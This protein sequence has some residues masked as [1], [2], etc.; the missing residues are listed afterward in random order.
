MCLS[1]CGTYTYSI[2]YTQLYILYV[3][4]FSTLY[5]LYTYYSTYVLSLHHYTHNTLYT[6]QYTL[7]SARSGYS[8][9]R[10]C[11]GLWRPGRHC[12]TRPGPAVSVRLSLCTLCCIDYV[13]NYVT[14]CICKTVAMYTLL[15]RLCA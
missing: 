6:I 7:R 9:L 3:Y 13:H 11:C 5:I 10:A 12:Y 4:V 2:W 15:Y 14:T 8:E 1:V